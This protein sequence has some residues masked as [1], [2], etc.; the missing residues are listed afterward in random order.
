MEQTKSGIIIPT[1]RPAQCQFCGQ[2]VFPQNEVNGKFHF[3]DGKIICVQCRIIKS[4]RNARGMMLDIQRNLPKDLK[5]KE[6]ARQNR[7]NDHA[8]QVAIESQKNSDA[9]MDKKK[10]IIQIP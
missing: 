1:R 8:I 4:N 5:E 2:Q 9:K 6:R 7:A 10:I 3:K